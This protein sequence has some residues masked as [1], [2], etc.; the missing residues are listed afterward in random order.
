MSKK[1]FGYDASIRRDPRK[2]HMYFLEV[3]F[4][5]VSFFEYVFDLNK[6]KKVARIPAILRKYP[7]CMTMS[8]I[9][10]FFD[11]DGTVGKG[12]VKFVQ[13][14]KEIL[15]QIKQ[16]LEEENITASLHFDRSWNGW[17]LR[18][19][20]NCRQKFFSLTSP[21][22]KTRRT[23]NTMGRWSS[24]DKTQASGRYPGESL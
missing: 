22:L 18:V 13:K 11:A 14:S 23:K 9:G 16:E 2:K 15:E 17:E 10:G 19:W 12:N 8:F 6:G 4:K 21:R 1:L 5:L 7:K 20:R 24:L 3:H